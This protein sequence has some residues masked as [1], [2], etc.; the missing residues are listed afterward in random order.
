MDQVK[1]N[2]T[3]APRVAAEDALEEEGAGLPPPH[4][5][6]RPLAT[7][8]GRMNTSRKEHQQRSPLSDAPTRQRGNTPATS[9]S[10]SSQ[11]PTLPLLV[12]TARQRKKARNRHSQNAEAA[13]SRIIRRWGG[14]LRHD[15]LRPPE[16]REEEEEP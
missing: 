9:H 13:H 15:L 4:H 14:H 1:R 7:T 3:E 10:E 11:S 12:A 8:A 2:S 16:L 5:R 6:R